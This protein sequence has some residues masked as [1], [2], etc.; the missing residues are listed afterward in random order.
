VLLGFFQASYT[1]SNVRIDICYR[2][3][4]ILQVIGAGATATADRDWHQI[5]KQSPE[6]TNLQSEIEKIHA[7]GRQ[8]PAV[9]T[10]LKSEFATSWS[11]QVLT[12]LQRDAQAHWRDPTY[13]MAKLALNIV[14][15]LLIGFTFFHA[16]DSIQ[17]TQNKLFVRVV[18]RLIV[19]IPK[20][21]I[22]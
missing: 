6:A 1:D 20:L 16:K 22:Q 17:S 2:A 11:Y 8:R 13:I 3:E 15:G 14:S 21:I 10:A 7:E 19:Y 18:S 9:E 12:L 4:Y 5:W